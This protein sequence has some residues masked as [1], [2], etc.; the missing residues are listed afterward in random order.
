MQAHD[1]D[2]TYTAL[3]QAV[4]AAGARS[5]L[6]L[7]MLS[8]KLISQSDDAPWVHQQIQSVLHDLQTHEKATP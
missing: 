7:A 8:L 4:H 2:S 5:E 3:A 6:L 1:L